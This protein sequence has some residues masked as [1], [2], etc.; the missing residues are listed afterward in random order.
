MH[1]KLSN[2]VYVL[3]WNTSYCDKIHLQRFSAYIHSHE[4]FV[5]L[6]NTAQ[7]M[8]L[9]IHEKY[10]KSTLTKKESGEAWCN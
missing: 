2:R 1:S 10:A 4:I 6:W 3:V 8:W 9:N 5:V 7:K